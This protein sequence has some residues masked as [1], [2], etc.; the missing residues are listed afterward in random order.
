L[1][2]VSSSQQN[3]DR[4]F[5]LHIGGKSPH[6]NTER[7]IE[8][9][10]RLELSDITLVVLGVGRND[11]LC[12][13]YSSENIIFPGRITDTEVGDLFSKS[14][15]VVMP[16]LIEGYGLPIIEG[17]T[18]GVPVLTSKLPPMDEIAGGAAHLVNPYSVDSIEHG[19][20][21]V[22]FNGEYASS[23]ICAGRER[24]KEINSSAFCKSFVALLKLYCKKEQ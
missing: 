7:V 1:E 5:I 19:I 8:A 17:F 23:L 14:R 21:T 4:K 3:N 10:K 16:S 6:K 12:K 24:L 20:R 11:K 2:R 18:A 9:F 22:L 15:M 13:S